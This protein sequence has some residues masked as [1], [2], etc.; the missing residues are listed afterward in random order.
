MALFLLLAIFLMLILKS[1]IRNLEILEKHLAKTGIET[2]VEN[3]LSQQQ[4]VSVL[5]K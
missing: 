1:N 4:E 5:I 3:N 2:E